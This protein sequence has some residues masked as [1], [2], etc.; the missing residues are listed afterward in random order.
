MT[1]HMARLSQIHI[2]ECIH[3]GGHL[4]D[5][6]LHRAHLIL[7]PLHAGVDGGVQARIP[8][9]IWAAPVHAHQVKRSGL[10]SGPGKEHHCDP[11]HMSAAHQEHI[12]LVCHAAWKG[13]NK[14]DKEQWQWVYIHVLLQPTSQMFTNWSI[15][16]L[17]LCASLMEAMSQEA[18]T[19]SL[20]DLCTRSCLIN[21]ALYCIMQDM[22]LQLHNTI[23]AH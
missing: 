23:S 21:L 8:E 10:H 19:G 16:E 7:H 6:G 5:S 22:F 14:G 17:V 15:H 2:H 1:G 13:M 4:I 18:T 3:S 20:P 11:L 9:L 12:E